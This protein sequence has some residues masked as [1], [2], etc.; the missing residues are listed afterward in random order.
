MKQKELQK[1]NIL[2]HSYNLLLIST[3]ISVAQLLCIGYKTSHILSNKL[4]Q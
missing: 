4:S 1:I 2:I 3:S